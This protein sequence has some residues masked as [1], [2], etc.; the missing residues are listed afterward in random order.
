MKNI[1][2]LRN[3]IYVQI[4]RVIVNTCFKTQTYKYKLHF[5]TNMEAI[6]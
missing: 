4:Q 5:D 1:T 2:I 6:I 3:T